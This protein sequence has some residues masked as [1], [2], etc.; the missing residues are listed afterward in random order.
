MNLGIVQASLKKN[1]S[2][3]RSYAKA[4]LHRRNYP[5]CYYNLGNLVRPRQLN[6]DVR[7][8]FQLMSWYVRG[9]Q[10]T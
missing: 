5:D 8:C 2:A 3:E 10:T 7:I 1:S 9:K 4:I 6:S